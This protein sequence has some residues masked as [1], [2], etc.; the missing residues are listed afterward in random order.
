MERYHVNGLED[1]R[2]LKFHLFSNWSIDSKKSQS[3]PSMLFNRIKQA[4][5]KI[6]MEMQKLQGSQE[7]QSGVTLPDIKTYFKTIVIKTV[8]LMIYMC[9]CIF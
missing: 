8:I 7:E 3:K 5:A 4:I 6:Y 9:V 2:W 1:S